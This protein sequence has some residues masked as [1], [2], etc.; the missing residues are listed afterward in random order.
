MS[1]LTADIFLMSPA[2]IEIAKA[3]QQ[4]W[5]QYTDKQ[6]KDALEQIKQTHI[7][8][9]RKIINLGLN[10]EVGA[11]LITDIANTNLALVDVHFPAI[12]ERF[13]SVFTRQG[14]NGIVAILSR[15]SI[16]QD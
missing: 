6:G 7:A 10:P 5:K 8:H 12:G 16:K 2:E 1:N 3:A 9:V 15:E 13:V 4:Q 11:V 14:A